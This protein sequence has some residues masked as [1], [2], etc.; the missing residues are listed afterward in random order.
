MIEDRATLSDRSERRYPVLIGN[1]ATRN[2]F[3]VR[4]IYETTT[5]NWSHENYPLDSETEE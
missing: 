2:H 4:P 5:E 1:R 3:L